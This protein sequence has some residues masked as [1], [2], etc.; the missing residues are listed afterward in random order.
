MF[1][2]VDG[3][4]RTAEIPRCGDDRASGTEEPKTGEAKEAA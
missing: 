4:R 1:T 2:T 3:N